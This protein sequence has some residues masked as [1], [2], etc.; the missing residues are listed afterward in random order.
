MVGKEASL[1]AAAQDQRAEELGESARRGGVRPSWRPER[2]QLQAEHTR[3]HG[4]TPAHLG[5]GRRKYLAGGDAPEA[6]QVGVARAAD[7]QV[8][9]EQRMEGELLD[10]EAGRCGRAA[11]L[12]KV[13]RPLD[14]L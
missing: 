13:D 9:A 6:P 14:V 1:S 8:G 4:K 11:E 5:L 7:G 2:R 10:S 12:A 3:E